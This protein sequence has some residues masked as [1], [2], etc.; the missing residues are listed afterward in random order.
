MEKDGIALNATGWSAG[1]VKG[2]WIVNDITLTVPKGKLVAILGPNGAGKTTLLKSIALQTKY[3]SGD[4]TIDSTDIRGL[5]VAERSKYVAY[6][7]SGAGRCDMTVL[8]YVLTG[9]TADRSLFALNETDENKALALKAI[10]STN[11]TALKRRKMSTLSDGQRQLAVAARA[12]AQSPRLLLLDEPTSNL[13]LKNQQELLSILH[14]MTRQT[15]MSVIMILHDIN[16]AAVWADMC[17][18]I[19]DGRIVSFGETETVLAEETLEKAFG[20]PFH[21]FYDEYHHKKIFIS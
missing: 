14:R 15:N 17:A 6:V 3:H 18:V 16:L 9:R 12:L 19:R 10:E 21:S 7:A 4:L 1:F 20:I 11:I 5:S 8:S 13:D 2:E